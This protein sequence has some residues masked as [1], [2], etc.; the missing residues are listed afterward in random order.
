ME[1]KEVAFVWLL[2]N[3]NERYSGYKTWLQLNLTLEEYS[4]AIQKFEAAS[5]KLNKKES[6][7]IIFKKELKIAP[8]GTMT[9]TLILLEN[10]KYCILTERHNLVYFICKRRF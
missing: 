9:R 5:N 7:K 6:E 1:L 8:H 3:G 4:E 2:K 10:E